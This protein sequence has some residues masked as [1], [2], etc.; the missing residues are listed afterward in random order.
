MKI[1]TPEQIH[2]K[3]MHLS[4]KTNITAINNLF[5]A[6]DESRHWPVNGKFNATE[7]AIKNARKY[8]ER[9]CDGL[10]YCLTLDRWISSIVNG[11]V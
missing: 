5:R 11:E 2:E 4:G 3:T 1:L 6:Q 8:R 10:A 7:R 9:G